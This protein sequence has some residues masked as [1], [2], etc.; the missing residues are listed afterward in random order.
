MEETIRIQYVVPHD[1]YINIYVG[2]KQKKIV[3]QSVLRT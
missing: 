3:Y 1:K 2:R